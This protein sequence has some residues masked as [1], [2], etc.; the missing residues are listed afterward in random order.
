MN[1]RIVSLDGRPVQDAKQYQEL[2]EKFTDEKPIVVAVQRGKDRT[3]IETRIVLPRRDAGVTARVEAQYLPADKE[4]QIVSRT[5]TEMR[6]TVP[7]EW[8]P[9]SLFWNGLSLENLK[10]PGCWTLSMQKEL[11]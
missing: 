11:L 2:L 3:R 8:L 1:D 10:E 4:I 6:V 7:P 9:V 5:I